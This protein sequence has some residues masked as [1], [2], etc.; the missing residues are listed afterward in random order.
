M[1]KTYRVKEVF[2]PTIQGEGSRSGTVVLFLRLAGCNRWTGLEKDRAKSICSF[3]DTDFRGG[4][5]LT[6]GEIVAA[7][8]HQSH[9]VKTVVISGGEPTLQIDGALLMAL[10]VAGYKLHM[11]TNGSRAIGNLADYFEH[12]TM[13]PKQTRAETK[14]EKATD[15]KVLYPAPGS[16]S[17][18]DFNDF[19]AQHKFLQP[20]WDK[21]YDA[22]LRA[23]V[24]RLYAH[25]DWRLSLQTHKIMGVQ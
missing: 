16:I 13:S 21:D 4:I 20:V 17:F 5:P 18:E 11:E 10:K 7:L 6:A 23:T 19:P 14:L 25:P 9:S 22:T 2:G 12:I 3:C 8:E 15:V 24:C 1:S